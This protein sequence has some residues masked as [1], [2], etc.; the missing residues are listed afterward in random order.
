MKLPL[1]FVGIILLLASCSD[2]IIDSSEKTNSNGLQYEL[3][4][5]AIS[6]KL[7]T[8]VTRSDV[9]DYLNYR[10]HITPDQLRDVIRYDI[11]DSVYVYIVNV[12]S[13][14]WFILSGDYSSTPILAEEETGTFNLDFENDYKNYLKRWFQSIGNTITYNKESQSEECRKNREEWS[15]S[16]RNARIKEK[17]TTRDGSE[18]EVSIDVAFDTLIFDYYPALTVTEWDDNYPFQEALPLYEPGE[19]CFAG[20][21]V[22][23][24]AQLIYYTHFA[25]GYPNN[26]YEEASCSQYYNAPGTPPYTYTFIN[27]STTCWNQMGLTSTTN[28]FTPYATALYALVASNSGTAYVLDSGV[29]VGS[30]QPSSIVPT[31]NSF[32]LYGASSQNFNKLS[33]INEIQNERP[34]LCYGGNDLTD[35]IG[36]VF[37][38]DG[39]RW[40][41]IRETETITDEQGNMEVNVYMHDYFAWYINAGESA[42]DHRVT[43]VA[44]TTYFYHNRKM[45]IGWD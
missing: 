36:H 20:C 26:T 22:V 21:A 27:P 43:I 17:S 29:G 14:G 38:I 6:A 15:R 32:Q 7:S 23:A 5:K 12:K 31:L 9:E 18:T 30:T 3:L 35:T 24:I 44:D 37:L 25:L 45:Y 13:G 10:K 11:N 40:E 2:S 1:I 39:Y 34:V 19:H 41:K 16:I 4:T 8:G 42:G 33:A 28:Y